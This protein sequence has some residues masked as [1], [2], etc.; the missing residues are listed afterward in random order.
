ML[1]RQRLALRVAAVFALLTAATHLV[2]EFL[3]FQS[4]IPAE[5]ELIRQATTVRMRLPGGTERTMMNLIDGFG[6]VFVIFAAVTAA[7]AFLVARRASSDPALANAIAR[8]LAAAYIV[9]TVVSITKFF[10]IPTVSVG[11]VALALI[12]AII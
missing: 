1:P 5:Q 6:L 11:A 7:I 10:I 4:D 8:M 3:G 9:L 12:A 2:G